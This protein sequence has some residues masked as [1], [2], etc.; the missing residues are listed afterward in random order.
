M[1]STTTSQ[2]LRYASVVNTGTHIEYIHTQIYTHIH[3]PYTRTCP[4]THTDG[5]RE[6]ARKKMLEG[7]PCA[8][9]DVGVVYE[10]RERPPTRCHRFQRHAAPRLGDAGEEKHV[11]TGV[12]LHIQNTTQTQSHK[13]H[14]TPHTHHTTHTTHPL[15]NTFTTQIH[16]THTTPHTQDTREPMV[17]QICNNTAV[18]GSFRYQK[19]PTST[20]A[21]NRADQ[22]VRQHQRTILFLD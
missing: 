6:R 4:K 22:S 14:R 7:Y 10:S 15:H 2:T 19:R 17:W 11:G 8:R 12:R 1:L 13:K 18:W 20:F 5:N 21:T 16:A 9:V 3:P